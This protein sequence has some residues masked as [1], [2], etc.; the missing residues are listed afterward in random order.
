MA[1]NTMDISDFQRWIEM[2][3]SRSPGPGG[4]NVNKVNTRVTL[5][6]DFE[7][8]AAFS[9]IQKA[10]LRE[11]LR[12]RLSHDGRLRVVRHGERT[13]GRNR[14]AAESR[15]VELVSEALRQDK[16]RK[17]TRPTI[18]SGKRRLES[19]RRRGQRKSQ[20]QIAAED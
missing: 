18:S 12:T 15:V 17:S 5:L 14:K 6:L 1:A 4:Q 16:T 10:K 8:C 3:F 9:E 19:K 2:R 13:Q 11:R 20:R 7:S